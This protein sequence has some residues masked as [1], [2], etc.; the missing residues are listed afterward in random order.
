[1]KD[2]PATEKEESDTIDKLL[3]LL[4]TVV[5][6]CLTSHPKSRNKI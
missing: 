1:M 2:V 5:A 3:R 4:Y 6:I